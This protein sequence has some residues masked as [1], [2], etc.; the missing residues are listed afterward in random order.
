LAPEP[1]LEA[2]KRKAE[3]FKSKRA[4]KR[5]AK[6]IEISLGSE[7][8]FQSAPLPAPTVFE[9]RAPEISSKQA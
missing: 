9:E 7:K 3:L 2:D 4:A 1:A 8:H 6:F 5:R